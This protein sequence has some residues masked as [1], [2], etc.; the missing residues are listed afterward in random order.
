M[1]G[2]ILPEVKAGTQQP[3]SVAAVTAVCSSAA[4]RNLMSGKYQ[5]ACSFYDIRIDLVLKFKIWV[6]D[7]GWSTRRPR[8]K[9]PVAVCALRG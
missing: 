7:S 5:M 2:S 6:A 4:S 1:L 3:R 9:Q 8:R